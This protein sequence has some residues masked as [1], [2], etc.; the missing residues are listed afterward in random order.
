VNVARAVLV[1]GGPLVVAVIICRRFGRAESADE[2]DQERIAHSLV[3]FAFIG[4]LITFV[5]FPIVSSPAYA[6][7]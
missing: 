6:R 1:L 2:P 7:Y 4:G 5:I 3:C